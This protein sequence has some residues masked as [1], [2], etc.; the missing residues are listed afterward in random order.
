MIYRP[1]DIGK[2]PK[3]KAKAIEDNAGRDVLAQHFHIG[4]GRDYLGGK[5][6]LDLKCAGCFYLEGSCYPDK[7]LDSDGLT[8]L[9]V[10]VI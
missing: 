9:L 1:I 6:I 3:D 5:I 2:T 8:A 10:K 7:I 4:K